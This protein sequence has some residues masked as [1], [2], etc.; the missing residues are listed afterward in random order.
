MYDI[1]PSKNSLKIYKKYKVS[2]NSLL[3]IL[4]VPWPTIPLVNITEKK[5]RKYF[6]RFMIFQLKSGS[7]TENRKKDIMKTTFG[8]KMLQ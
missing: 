2:N 8:N 5:D 7:R 4:N 3:I 6:I 1:L